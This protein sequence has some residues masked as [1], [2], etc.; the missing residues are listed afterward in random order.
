MN[1]YQSQIINLIN[2]ANNKIQIA[3][4]WF[5][6][7]VILDHLI[8][9]APELSIS[10]LVSSDEV[11]LFR[12]THFRE[13]INRGATVKKLGSSSPF[14]GMFMHSKFI[15]LDEKTAYG[16][17]YNFTSNAQNNYES[18]KKWDVSELT[19]TISD[20]KIWIGNA[21]DFFDGVTN[22]E[23]IVR[24]L[25]DRFMEEEAKRKGFL[26]RLSGGISSS[27]NVS[28][29]SGTKVRKH[30]FHGGK[31]FLPKIS[32]RSKNHY[33][34]LYYQ[35]HHLTKQF[36]AFK[37][38]VVDGVLIA[39]GTLKPTDEC[40]EYKVRIEYVPGMQPRVYVKSHE[41]ENIAEIHLYSEGFL[42]L[43]DPSETKWKDTNKLSEYTIPWTVEWILYYELWKI[44]G[45][46][47]GQESKH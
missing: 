18:F 47:E 46:W 27:G 30:S 38:N 14:D 24:K 36:N 7:D 4:S 10:V 1:N 21:V 15:I 32:E 8:K 6:D 39:N 23:A 12:H 29:G 34:L 42:C 26:N 33:S 45:K 17:S 11:N 25:K 13:L 20:F 31:A 19:R 9:K 2:F 16:G 43:F 44:T 40:D 28:S 3:V 35:K 41:L 37:A 22:A 5:T